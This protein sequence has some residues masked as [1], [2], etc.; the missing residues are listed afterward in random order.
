MLGFSPPFFLSKFTWKFC[1]NSSAPVAFSASAGLP[2]KPSWMGQ[3][4]KQAVACSLCRALVL[5]LTS[6]AAS[7][8]IPS[9]VPQEPLLW[10]IPFGFTGPWGGLLGANWHSPPISHVQG[11]LQTALRGSPSP[12]P[13]RLLL[14]PPLSDA[15]SPFPADLPESGEMWKVKDKTGFY[16]ARGAF[17]YRKEGNTSVGFYFFSPSSSKKYKGTLC[18]K[19][20]C[21]L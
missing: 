21:R 1:N 15:S 14:L 20:E 5:Q 4:H 2:S 10:Q 6:F 12:A 3:E 17:L 16:R 11:N 18:L 8:L 9:Q 7:L 19:C 13:N